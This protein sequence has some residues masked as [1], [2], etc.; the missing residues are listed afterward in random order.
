MRE[1]LFWVYSLHKMNWYDTISQNFPKL[2]WVQSEHKTWQL[3]FNSSYSLVV[4]YLWNSAEAS[5]RTEGKSYVILQKM[6]CSFYIFWKA[7]SQRTGKW[8]L[9]KSVFVRP[10]AQGSKTLSCLL[11]GSCTSYWIPFPSNS[12]AEGALLHLASITWNSNSIFLVPL[13]I[14][15]CWFI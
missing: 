3:N 14:L 12:I 13:L 1:H 6:I 7:E 8:I 11:T 10:T 15:G 9:A 2:I 4:N 5:L